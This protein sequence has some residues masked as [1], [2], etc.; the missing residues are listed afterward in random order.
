[1]M[2]QQL[3]SPQT[4]F[5]RVLSSKLTCD[6]RSAL[7]VQHL[8]WDEYLLCR[9]GPSR[10]N[11]SRACTANT[12]EQIR[13]SLLVCAWRVRSCVHRIEMWLPSWISL[14]LALALSS[15]LVA[16]NSMTIA[17]P[18]LQS[19]VVWSRKT[20]IRNVCGWI[21]AC[22]SLS[23]LYLCDIYLSC[24]WQLLATAEIRLT[25]LL[26]TFVRVRPWL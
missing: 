16:I 3:L 26:Q 14:F 23:S 12:Y 18:L 20:G 25:V 8:E 15:A 6:S 10:S 1:M 24:L 4:W 7:F 9:S 11:L 13:I 2:P 19:V 21:N 22:T 17:F 5:L